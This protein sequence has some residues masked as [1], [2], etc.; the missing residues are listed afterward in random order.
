M[1]VLSCIKF[2]ENKRR[3][4]SSWTAA[5]VP[6]VIDVL[7]PQSNMTPAIHIAVL[8]HICAY[9]FEGTGMLFCISDVS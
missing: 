3:N 2:T 9:I 8:R 1:Q 7:L 5:T 6:T 4:R